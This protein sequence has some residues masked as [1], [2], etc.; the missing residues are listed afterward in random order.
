MA[1]V[2]YAYKV[3]SQVV[4][5]SGEIAPNT[6]R[7]RGVVLAS[8]TEWTTVRWFKSGD[9]ETFAT[10]SKQLWTEGS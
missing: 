10:G 7:K 1:E 6:R 5:A 9:E 4:R 3:G 2:T 8:D